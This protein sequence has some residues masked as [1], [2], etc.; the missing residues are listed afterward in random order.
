[1]QVEHDSK[2]PDMLEAAQESKALAQRE[3]GRLTDENLS[4]RSEVEGEV[5]RLA[6]A[7]SDPL[8]FVPLVLH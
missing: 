3:L 5:A 1:M 4:L 8:L 6:L 2:I 7:M